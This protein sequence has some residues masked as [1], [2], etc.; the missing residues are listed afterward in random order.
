MT[1]IASVLPEDLCTFV[2]KPGSILLGLRNISGKICR[3]N[4]NTRFVFRTFFRKWCRLWDGVEI[5][6]SAR[7]ATYG[8]I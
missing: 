4:Q 2:M 7:D 1:R 6:G 3:G 8:N 5:Y